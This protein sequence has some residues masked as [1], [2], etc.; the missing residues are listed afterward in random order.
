MPLEVVASDEVPTRLDP[1]SASGIGKANDERRKIVHISVAVANEK[2]SERRLVSRLSDYHKCGR[3]EQR[4]QEYVCDESSWV[5]SFVEVRTS[6]NRFGITVYCRSTVTPNA[7][8]I[9]P[10][11]S[12]LC[13]ASQMR[14][15]HVGSASSGSSHTAS[16][17]AMMLIRLPPTYSPTKSTS[18]GIAS[19]HSEYRFANWSAVIPSGTSAPN[20]A[21]LSL[22]ILFG[23]GS[24]ALRSSW[25]FPFLCRLTL[26]DRH[27]FPFFPFA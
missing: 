6:Y 12:F 5:I 19:S 20:W 24:G 25:R 27:I 26:F 8:V 1:S 3:N 4:K 21:S 13:D 15:R 22:H 17:L 18:A 16:S 14:K 2:H 23:R 10:Y 11:T 7:F 9:I